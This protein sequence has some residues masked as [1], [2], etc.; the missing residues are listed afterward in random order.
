MTSAPQSE[1]RSAQDLLALSDSFSL[2]KTDTPRGNVRFQIKFS[3]DYSEPELRV[4]A[5]F[6]SQT[7]G[8]ELRKSLLEGA[9]E[10]LSDQDRAQYEGFV[11][12]RDAGEPMNQMQWTLYTS[13][14]FPPNPDISVHMPVQSGDERL[15][16]QLRLLNAGRPPLET[17]CLTVLT[18]QAGAQELE[19]LANTIMDQHVGYSPTPQETR[20]GDPEQPQG[21]E[22][23][24][25]I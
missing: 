16:R 18:S 7:L 3:H 19:K 9:L 2:K 15:L 24:P 6:L 5:S 11:R 12:Q 21:F 1:G 10:R 14:Y 17:P 8:D 23:D 13:M 22:L 25:K 20:D 4:I